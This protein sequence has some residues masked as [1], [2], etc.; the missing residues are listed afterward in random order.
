M[1]VFV[2]EE[3]FASIL[4]NEMINEYEISD[5][6]AFHNPYKKKLQRG[7]NLLKNLVEQYGKIMTSIENNKDYCVYEI[8]SLSQ[9]LGVRYCLC[10]IIDEETKKPKG[11]V[12]V[13][14]LET[15]K[16]KNY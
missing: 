4:L 7:K 8:Y 15:F 13:K 5:G 16:I 14:P 6:N 1:K 11:A 12:L 9:S 10:R 2:N 3:K